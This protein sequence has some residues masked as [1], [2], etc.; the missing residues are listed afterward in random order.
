MPDTGKQAEPA[1]KKRGRPGEYKP[2]YAEQ[3]RMLCALGATDE[4]LASF[5][6]VSA[7]TVYRWTAR[8]ADFCQALKSGKDPADDRVERS[9]YHRA[10]G[11]TFDAVK[12]VQARGE[13]K[14]V[15]YKEHLPPDT[16]AAIFWLKNRRKEHWRDAKDHALTGADGGPLQ[17]VAMSPSK[18]EEIARRIRDEF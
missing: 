15:P 1:D 13:I 3:A 8:H 7:R 5:F 10:V 12:I 18:F 4:D 9:L 2:E 11:Y 17:T 14:L 16:T 6:K